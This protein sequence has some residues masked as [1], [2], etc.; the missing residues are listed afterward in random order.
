MVRLSTVFSAKVVAILL[1][2]NHVRRRIHICCDSR[3]AVAALATTT[4]ESS[5]ASKCMQVLGKLSEFNN[6]T[7]VWTPRHQVIGLLGNE[8]AD[9]L[10]KEGAIEVPLNQFTVILF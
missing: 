8:E 2:K 9:R 3:A 5:L 10:A 6:V 7:L 1:T 4:T